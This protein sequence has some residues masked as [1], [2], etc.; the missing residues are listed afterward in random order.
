MKWN[1]QIE[2]LKNV[3]VIHNKET[4]DFLHLKIWNCHLLPAQNVSKW[5]EISFDLIFESE[6]L[7]LYYFQ[8]ELSF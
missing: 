6:K 3:S 7:S 4:W 2:D 5:L 8:I 1:G